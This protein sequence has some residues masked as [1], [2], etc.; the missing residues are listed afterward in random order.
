[1]TLLITII[2]AVIATVAWYQH[3][4]EDTMKV[5][6]LCF[7]YWGASIMWFVD[8]ICE[9]TELKADYFTPAV[10][11]MVNDTFLGFSVVAFGLVIWV[12]TLLVKDPKGVVQNVMVRNK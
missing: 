10:S 7:L 8:A 11:D 12:C 9:Y 1:M 5:S 3:A 4:P 2:A 6:T